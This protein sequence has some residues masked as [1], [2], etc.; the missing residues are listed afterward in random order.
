MR[1][2]PEGLA[3]AKECFER[4]LEIDPIML[5][6]RRAGRRTF[7]SGC[8][9]N[10]SHSRHGAL[11][12]EAAENALSIESGNS[13]AHSVLAIMAGIFDYDWKMAETHHS[14]AMAAESVLP[15]TRFRYAAFY[16]L[17]LGP[18]L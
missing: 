3:K 12:E 14:T 4:A 18:R 5:G 17:P 9:R 15:V 16:L 13:E 2:T 8:A 7:W 11:G 10:K 6:L 1:N